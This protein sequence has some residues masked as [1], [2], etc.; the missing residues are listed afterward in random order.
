MDWKKQLIEM[1]HL[2]EPATDEAILLALR[3]KLDMAAKG[4]RFA[5]AEE[6]GRRHRVG[7]EQALREHDC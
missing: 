1:L 5:H 3:R 6:Y 2:E 7:I 4:E